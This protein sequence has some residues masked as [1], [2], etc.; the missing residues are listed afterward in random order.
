MRNGDVKG[1][2]RGQTCVG[3]Q[4]WQGKGCMVAKVRTQNPMERRL[5]GEDG[6]SFGYSQ[7]NCVGTKQGSV[8]RN[9]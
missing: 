4:D 2:P 6:G 9:V 5:K 7:G 1:S 3:L 8:A